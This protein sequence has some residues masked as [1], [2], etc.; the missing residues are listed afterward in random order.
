MSIWI[1]GQAFL[2]NILDVLQ[3]ALPSSGR[4][5]FLDARALFARG[6]LIE[7]KL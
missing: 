6:A 1:G 5:F 2:E 7:E 4:Q 3:T